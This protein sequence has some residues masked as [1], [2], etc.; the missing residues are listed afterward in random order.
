MTVYVDDMHLRLMGSFGS[1]KMCHM[2]ADS[3]DELHAMADRIGVQRKWWQRPPQHDSHYD[4]AMSKREAA[5][6]L[7]AIAVTMR[8]CA[9]MVAR[10]RVTGALGKPDDALAWLTEYR[11]RLRATKTGAVESVTG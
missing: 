6:A 11:T 7:G 4:I 2:V 5:L 1:M 10:R 3:D 8:Q 9:A